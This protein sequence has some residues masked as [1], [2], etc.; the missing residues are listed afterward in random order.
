MSVATDGAP[1]MVGRHRGFIAFLKREVP[2]ILAVHCVIHRQH[3][4]AKNLSDRLHQSLQYVIS[5]VNKIRCDAFNDR[6]FRQLCKINDEE[7]N[8]LLLHTEIRWLSKGACLNRFW[9]LFDSV[10]EFLEDKDVVL[11]DRLLEFKI[12]VAHM[13]DLFAKFNGV[14]LQLQG[15][16]LNLITSKS[17]FGRNEFSQ[18]PILSNI[19]KN[20]EIS[21]DDTQE[22]CQHLESLHMDFS[23]RFK[24]VLT[25]EVPQWVM[26]PYVNIET[27]EVHIQEELVE[28]S[29]YETLK[30]S[31]QNGDRLT[32]FWLQDNISRLYPGLCCDGSS[33]KKEKST[34]NRATRGLASS[35]H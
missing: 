16:E 26:N 2:D 34:R 13:T 19:K 18:F 24:N 9:N 33:H 11:K 4:V 21:C 10:L 28:L 17:N 29:T 8:R 25:L 30:A 5:A 3:L 20:G 31:F 1:A 12:D 23:N 15:D 22:Y 7:F 14:N 6:L 32:E 35:P 27:A